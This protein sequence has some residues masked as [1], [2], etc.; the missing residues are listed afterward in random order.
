MLG[1][2][3]STITLF[4]VNQGYPNIADKDDFNS[5]TENLARKSCFATIAALIFASPLPF[6]HAQE[7]QPKD[8]QAGRFKPWSLFVR[9]GD[10]YQFKTD[11]DAGGEFSVNRLFIQP[12]IRFLISRKASAS[13]T[14]G[15][16]HNDYDFS[17]RQGFAGLRPWGAVNT[18]RFSVPVRW[19]PNDKWTIFGIPTLRFATE[20]GASL[21]EGATGGG[22]IAASYKVS[23]KLSIGPGLGVFSQIE[24]D[25]TAFPILAIDWQLMDNL[26]LKTGRGIAA[27]QGPGLTLEWRPTDA[28]DISLEGRYEKFRFRLDNSGVAPDGVGE[29]RSV[30]IAL[31]A[32]YRF[33]RALRLA[34]TGGVEFAGRLRLEDDRGN[35][36]VS[37]DYDPVPFL[38]FTFEAS[39]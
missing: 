24:D 8:G 15:F 35:K 38:G 32:N 1:N 17:G 11:I 4:S 29:D 20:S 9:G 10:V 39:F 31:S 23:E 12:G 36:I 28:L 16:G 27:T 2:L 30:P 3:L 26:S 21:N 34:L 25:V 6:S 33:D 13:F 14:I 5:P 19:S 7:G 22:L 18:W 37:T